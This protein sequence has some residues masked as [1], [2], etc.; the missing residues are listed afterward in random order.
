VASVEWLR[1]ALDDLNQLALYIAEDDP[2]AATRTVE[3]ILPSINQLDEYP[4][5]GRVGR[6][7]GTRELLVVGT[8]YLVPYRVHSGRVQILRIYHSARRWPKR[9]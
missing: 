7:P 2:F 5:S 9:F 3:K 6:V 1:R 4:A 8:P